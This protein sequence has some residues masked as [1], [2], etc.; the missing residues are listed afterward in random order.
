MSFLGGL[1]GW[2]AKGDRLHALLV[3]RPQRVLED[4]H[5]GVMVDG[6]ALARSRQ[7]ALGD[8]V[9]DREGRE[10]LVL[11]QHRQ[12]QGARTRA[13][14]S[15]RIA[16]AIGPS[17]PSM[18]IGRPTTSPTAWRSRTSLAKRSVSPA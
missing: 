8:R 9:L 18:L 12:A 2:E 1:E 7:A 13:A 3:K 5:G 4:H 6:L 10:P 16:L 14:A 11:Q 17:L 15:A